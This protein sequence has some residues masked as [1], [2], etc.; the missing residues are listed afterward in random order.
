MIATMQNPKMRQVKHGV[1]L[2]RV[3]PL[4]LLLC[5]VFGGVALVIH[6]WVERTT[7]TVDLDAYQ[8]EMLEELQQRE[9]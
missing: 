2:R 7:P 1:L 5:L 6:H 3:L 8:A 9:G 4:L